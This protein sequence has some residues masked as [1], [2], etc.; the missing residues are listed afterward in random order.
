MLLAVRQTARIVFKSATFWSAEGTRS[1]PVIGTSWLLMLMHRVDASHLP[2]LL[3]CEMGHG[4]PLAGSHPFGDLA[5][6]VVCGLVHQSAQNLES[7][8]FFFCAGHLQPHALPDVQG[9]ALYIF[10][11]EFQQHVIRE[12][13]QTGP[14]I[15][16]P[17]ALRLAQLDFSTAQKCG[18]VPM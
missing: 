18:S 9:P 15:G 16:K 7:V 11:C 4:L 17:P 8:C 1:F 14:T 5:P 13:G 12:Q 6:A 2:A 10:N 3:D